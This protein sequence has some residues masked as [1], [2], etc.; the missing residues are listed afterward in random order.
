MAKQNNKSLIRVY[1]H[2]AGMEIPK[3]MGILH[4]DRLK[5]K[6]I[7]SFEYDG[8]WL[9]NG[10][11]QLLDPNLQLYSGLHYLNGETRYFWNFFLIP[12]P[13]VWGQILNA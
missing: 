6:E 8:D 1:A 5:G 3:L 4:S 2:W 10:P 12:R 9:K 11:A 13:D 7:F